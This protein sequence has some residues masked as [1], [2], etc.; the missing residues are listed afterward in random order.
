MCLYKIFALDSS[1]EYN[2]FWKEVLMSKTIGQRVREA[3][4]RRGM[5]QAEL[6][7]QLRASVNAINM[8]EQNKI[9][10]PRASR[11]IGVAKVLQ[12]SADYLLGLKEK[13]EIAA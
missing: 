4:E 8:L 7:R 11:I 10:D 13:I 12:V 5:S 2:S 3:R 9:H 1:V 6:A